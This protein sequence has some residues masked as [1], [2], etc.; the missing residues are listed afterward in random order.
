MTKESNI[1]AVL[2]ESQE[3][4]VRHIIATIRF[5]ERELQ[6]EPDPFHRAYIAKSMSFIRSEM[7][8]QYV[9]HEPETV[10]R[11]LEEQGMYRSGHIVAIP[12]QS[13]ADLELKGGFFVPKGNP[14]LELHLQPVPPRER[15]REYLRAML[16]EVA[17][18]GQNLDPGCLIFA[19]TYPRVADMSE[20]LAGFTQ[21]EFN[22]DDHIA[23]GYR[24]RVAMQDLAQAYPDMLE[25]ESYYNRLIFTTPER[26]KTVLKSV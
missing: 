20:K 17:T 3:K 1:E 5:G 22:L 6:Q 16:G 13:T 4:Y 24:V 7:L 18:L 26:I 11:L 8:M 9:D 19:H 2:T 25:N 10:D 23:P 15:K 21:Q 14:M 12:T